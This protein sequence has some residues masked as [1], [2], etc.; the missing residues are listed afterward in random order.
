MLL[1]SMLFAT[2]ET[3]NS[4]ITLYE[5]AYF[6]TGNTKY[7]FDNMSFTYLELN[8]TCLTV[9][10]LLWK[11]QSNQRVNITFE[12]INPQINWA[13]ERDLITRF[14]VN[15]SSKVYFNISGLKTNIL[16]EISLDNIAIANVTSNH[17]GNI[18][19]INSDWSNKTVRIIQLDKVNYNIR[20]VS[21]QLIDDYLPIFI[22]LAGVAGVITLFAT[23]DIRAVLVVLLGLLLFAEV[24]KII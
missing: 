3:A 1:G 12:Y 14:I 20:R 9:N 15:A 5:N 2:C 24:M 23:N 10:D 22:V 13:N 11:I 21:N 8:E 6:Y 19:F 17:D 18:S 7:E 16:Y 4:E